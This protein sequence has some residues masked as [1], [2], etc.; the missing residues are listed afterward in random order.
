MCYETQTRRP[1]EGMWG[2][3][4]RGAGGG[5]GDGLPAPI[6]PGIQHVLPAQ[7]HLDSSWLLQGGGV[8]QWQQEH[9][10]KGKEVPGGEETKARAAS[11][12]RPRVR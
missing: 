8:A 1:S 7:P 12:P 9:A 2:Q 11:H 5:G 4:R 6:T 3:R 10:I